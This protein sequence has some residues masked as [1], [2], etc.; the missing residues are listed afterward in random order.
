LGGYCGNYNFLFMNERAINNSSEL[1]FGG[2][3]GGIV[4]PRFNH[5]NNSK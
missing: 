4:F 3:V 1:L 2:H 5:G